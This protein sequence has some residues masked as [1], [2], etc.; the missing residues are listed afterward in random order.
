MTD[1]YATR[2]DWLLHISRL[3]SG[4]VLTIHPLDGLTSRM[5]IDA[6]AAQ[7]I[8]YER[9]GF[10]AFRIIHHGTKVLIQREQLGPSFV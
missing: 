5:V 2:S 8:L 10:P 4:D 1:I 3:K 6:M 9:A 7:K